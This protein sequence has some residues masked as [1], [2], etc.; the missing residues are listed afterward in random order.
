MRITG[1]RMLELA[2]TAT[3]KAQT[4]IAKSSEQL[5]S[6]K[7]VSSASDDPL[8]WAQARR[9]A[10]RATIDAGRGEAVA[11]GRDHLRATET[12]LAIVSD[13]L[14]QARELAIGANN[15]MI[16]AADR[17]TMAERARSLFD[18]ALSAANARG[19]T[20]E[21]VLAGGQGATP[22]FAAT[23]LYQGDSATRSIELGDGVTGAITVAGDALTAASGVDVL[24]VLD[25]LATALAANDLPT[26]QSSIEELGRAHRQV[27]QARSSLGT[28][29]QALDESDTAR[30][31]LSEQLTARIADL[32]ETDFVRAASDLA[33][34][35]TALEA[36][37]AITARLAG[38][39]SP[40][41]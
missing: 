41:R 9:A 19:T 29:V 21:Y 6:G 11:A 10:V 40:S 37:R 8:A 23:G 32:T 13:A 28:L 1:S 25:R 4:D 30:A 33:R 35:T 34:G 15:S 27:N 12:P 38:L 36:S 3:S 17:A 18:T 24:P 31:E 22:P 16:S 39:L 2:A 5:T 20:G 7:R 14:A 26:I